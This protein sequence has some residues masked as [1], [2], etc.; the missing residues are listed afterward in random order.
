MTECESTGESAAEPGGTPRPPSRLLVIG[1]SARKK[2][3]PGPLT[4]LGRY[5]GPAFRVLRKYLSR[6]T[7]APAVLILSARYGLIDAN[8]ETPDYDLRMTPAA[9]DAL[10]P[11]VLRVLGER[12]AEGFAEVGVCLGRDYQTA[13]A[14]FEDLVPPGTAVTPITGGQGTRLRNLRAWLERGDGRDRVG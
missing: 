12:L 14:G 1:C 6:A 10:R 3:D 7:V 13:V 8:R 9:A 2:K 5:D 4:A 11:D